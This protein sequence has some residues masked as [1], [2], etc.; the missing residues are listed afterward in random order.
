MSHKKFG[1]DRFSRFD[2]YWIQT[3]RQTDRQTSQI[4]M[5]MDENNKK[6]LFVQRF[7]PD[8]RVVTSTEEGVIKVMILFSLRVEI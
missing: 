4:Y 6:L 3:D 7:F 5:E 2:I 1:P 8:A